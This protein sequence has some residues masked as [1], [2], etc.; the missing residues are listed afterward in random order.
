M[1]RRVAGWFPRGWMPATGKLVAR[2]RG[3]A[4]AELRP[5]YARDAD[6]LFANAGCWDL[7][8]AALLASLM[9]G[10]A[11]SLRRSMPCLPA[12]SM[13]PACARTRSDRHSLAV[14]RWAALGGTLLSIGV[15]FAI[16]GFNW[17]GFS[18][19]GSL[20]NVLDALLLCLRSGGCAAACH[21]P[22]GHVFK[23]RYRARCVCRS[24]GRDSGGVV[25]LWPDASGGYARADFTADGSRLC[26]AIP[27]SSRSVFGRRLSASP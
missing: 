6:A 27:G 11:A 9:S 26:T 25:A 4:G 12:I 3:T 1:R 19:V 24:C 22:D 14:G 13:R 21:V 23:T 2:L 10:L 15:A 7:G 5:G 17:R 8:L 20:S 16:S 18:N